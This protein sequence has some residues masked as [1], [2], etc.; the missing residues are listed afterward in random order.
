M[1][2]FFGF[3]NKDFGELGSLLRAYPRLRSVQTVG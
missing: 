2:A 3:E 1:T